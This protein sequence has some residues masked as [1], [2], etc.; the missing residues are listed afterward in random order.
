LSGHAFR[1]GAREATGVPAAVLVAGYLGF[2]ALAA[3][4]ETTFLE[5]ACGSA[6][7]LGAYFLLT[8]RNLFAGVAAGALTV[9][10]LKLAGTP[11]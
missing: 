9:W 1:Q 10:L 7:A 5:R 11:A 2:G 6:A 8:R 4:H 3:A